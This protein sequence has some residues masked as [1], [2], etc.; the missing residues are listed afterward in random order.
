MRLWLTADGSCQWDEKGRGAG[1][2][3]YVCGA[4][5]LKAAVKKKALARA[6][7]G[8]LKGLDVSALEA[9]LAAKS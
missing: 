9:A 5:C 8:Q 7:R 1:R 3:A 2:G 4:G 6:F